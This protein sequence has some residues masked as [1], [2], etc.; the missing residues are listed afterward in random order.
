MDLIGPLGPDLFSLA[1][2]STSPSVETLKSAR[3]VALS[4]IGYCDVNTAYA[5][6]VH[7]RQLQMR[8]DQLPFAIH[9]SARFD[10]PVPAIAL[11]VRELEI[12][13]HA[14]MG[15]H[16]FFVCRIVAEGTPREGVPL[17]HTSG[18]YQYFRT[19]RRTPLPAAPR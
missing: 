16:T 1:L 7:H 12:I 8:F 17:C 14:T 9:R 4:D 11:G 19:R 15:S 2:R 10:L 3:R 18:M 5:L 13:D 6:G